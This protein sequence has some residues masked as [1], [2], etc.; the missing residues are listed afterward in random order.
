MLFWQFFKIIFFQHIISGSIDPHNS[1]LRYPL[2]K[3]ASDFAHPNFRPIYY[4]ETPEDQKQAAITACGGDEKNLPCIFDFIATGDQDVADATKQTDK[5]AGEERAEQGR[6]SIIT[7]LYRDQFEFAVVILCLHA[8]QYPSCPS[9]RCIVVTTI[10]SN[11]FF[12]SDNF[13]V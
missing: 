4:D 6:L 10:V 5:T 7:Y 13:Q 11:F 2:R 8:K 9:N 3:N 12:D 1:S